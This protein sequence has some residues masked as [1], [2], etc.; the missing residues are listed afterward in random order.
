MNTARFLKYVWLFYNIMHGRVKLQKSNHRNHHHIIIKIPERNNS[1][2]ID[3][4]DALML[5]LSTI[6][7][8]LCIYQVLLFIISLDQVLPS[9]VSL[10]YSLIE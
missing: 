2:N 5:L 10:D 7:K 1:S 3:R 9:I 4:E 6:F 8:K